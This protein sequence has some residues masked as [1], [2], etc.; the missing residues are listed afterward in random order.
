MD[1]KLRK[2]ADDQ[3]NM[4]ECE[5]NMKLELAS[6]QNK[7]EARE[8]D[9]ARGKGATLTSRRDFSN[10]PKYSGKHDEFDEWKVKMVTF[11]SGKMNSRN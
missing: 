10:L 6:M 9:K 8:N 7:A 4:K 2:I 11:L 1:E 5:K 3:A